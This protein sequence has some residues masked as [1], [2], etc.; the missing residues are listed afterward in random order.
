MNQPLNDY[1]KNR[2]I[3]NNLPAICSPE[4]EF[5]LLQGNKVTYKELNELLPLGDKIVSKVKVSKGDN[6]DKTRII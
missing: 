2:E 3:R 1:L 6:P 5:Y 4:G